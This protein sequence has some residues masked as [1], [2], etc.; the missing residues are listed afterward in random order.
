ME[1]PFSFLPF[2]LLRANVT[3]YFVVFVSVRSHHLHALG[4]LPS[5]SMTC[6]YPRPIRCCENLSFLP[7]CC[8]TFV[9]FSTVASLI[10]SHSCVVI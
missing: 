3:L 4:S 5:A 1:D 10:H 2:P 6:K 8:S 9:P 7:V